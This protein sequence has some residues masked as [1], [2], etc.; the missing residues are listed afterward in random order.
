[1]KFVWRPVEYERRLRFCGLCITWFHWTHNERLYI[2][3]GW[4][5]VRGIPWSLRDSRLLRTLKS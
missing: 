1:V 3:L 2:G 4:P 5:W